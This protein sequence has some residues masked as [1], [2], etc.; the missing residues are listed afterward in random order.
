MSIRSYIRHPSDIPI[1]YQEDEQD[2][3]VGQE[4][5][6]DISKGGLSFCSARKLSPGSVITIRFS[7]VQPEFEAR[8]QVVWCHREAEGFV[9]GVAFTESSELYRVR[10]IE[11]VCHIRH[12]KAEV[13]ATEGR[14]LDGDQA[15]R[16]W[17]H[18]FAN[19]FPDFDDGAVS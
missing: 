12:Y 9:I 5:L 13:L 2:A 17:I 16:E 3:G 19:E 8:V 10:M 1:E 14:R 7:C 18:K 4:R 15:A 6:N 11:Q